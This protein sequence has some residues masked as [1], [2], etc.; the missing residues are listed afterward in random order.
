MGRVVA[1]AQ[2]CS[3]ARR[4]ILRQLRQRIQ[5]QHP[6]VPRVSFGAKMAAN[7]EKVDVVVIVQNAE[8]TSAAPTTDLTEH[9]LNEPAAP[10]STEPA[11]QPTTAPS[12]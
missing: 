5:R 2:K 3:P 10:P 11:T 4:L 9:R 8:G 7:Q 12:K 1:Q 6:R